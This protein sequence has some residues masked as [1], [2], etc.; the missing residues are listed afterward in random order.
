MERC[1][2]IHYFE[3]CAILGFVKRVR[4][5]VTRM[6]IFLRK[7][8]LA[9]KQKAESQKPNVYIYIYIYLFIYFSPISSLINIY[10][11]SN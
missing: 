8:G 10:L 3:V 9:R 5:D 4:I 1:C 7:M 2:G 11:T 6:V